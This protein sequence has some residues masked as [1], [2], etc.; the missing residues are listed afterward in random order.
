MSEE[1]ILPCIH[2]I[3]HNQDGSHTVHHC[4]GNHSNADYTI[5]HCKCGLHAMDVRYFKLF[6]HAITE[7]PTVIELISPCPDKGAGW[8]HVESA[9]RR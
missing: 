2:H 3:H 9:I 7:T 1:R 6:A 4:G 5:I 8:F